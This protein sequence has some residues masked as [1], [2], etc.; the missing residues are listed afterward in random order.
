LEKLCCILNLLF[1]ETGHNSDIHNRY[2]VVV[3]MAGMKNKTEQDVSTEGLCYVL[4][5]GSGQNAT[6]SKTI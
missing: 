5:V 4:S 6:L 3:L 1:F 2:C